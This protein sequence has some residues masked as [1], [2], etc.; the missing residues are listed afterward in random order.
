MRNLTSTVAATL[1]TAAISA[2]SAQAEQPCWEGTAPSCLP[3]V[4]YN[5]PY[6]PPLPYAY[7][8]P[9]AYPNPAANGYSNYS[10][11]ENSSH[12]YITN[13]R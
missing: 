9:Y 3:P 6:P 13:P 8:T 1:L 4:T 10:P 11:F 2:A 12:A 5:P 7:P